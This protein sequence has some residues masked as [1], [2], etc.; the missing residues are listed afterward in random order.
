MHSENVSVSDL[1][2]RTQNRIKEYNN[3]MNGKLPT[4]KNEDGSL[5]DSILK[6][7]EDLDFYITRDIDDLLAE[8]EEE[9]EKILQAELKLQR[10]ANGGFTNDEIQAQKDKNGGLTDAELKIKNDQEEEARIAKEEARIA[11]EEADRIAQEEKRNT[12]PPAKKKG[13][14]ERVLDDDF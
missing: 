9:A 12:P 8:R 3:Y 2:E 4:Y 13:F 5:K 14:W 1:T 6:K 7:M 11:K 10:E